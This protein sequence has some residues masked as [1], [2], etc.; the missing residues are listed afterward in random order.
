M[1]DRDLSYA[2]A[3]AA[4]HQ[5]ERVFSEAT[6]HPGKT[7]NPLADAL[8][9]LPDVGDVVMA[10][11]RHAFD[12]A[13]HDRADEEPPAHELWDLVALLFKNLD[14]AQV[15]ELLGDVLFR[16]RHPAVYGTL[17]QGLRRRVPASIAEAALV[18]Q[19][20]STEARRRRNAVDLAYFLFQEDRHYLLSDAGRQ[21]LAAARA[22]L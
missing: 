20:R 21:I 19:L 2:E 9:R 8:A 17:A 11:L 15:T 22:T 18:V 14:D 6:T 10:F 7:T 3:L 13:A 12:P 1:R 5:A 4:L 16:A